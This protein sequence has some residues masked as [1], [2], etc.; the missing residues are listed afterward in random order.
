MIRQKVE[1]TP[2]VLWVTFFFIAYSALKILLPDAESAY[3]LMS[4]LMLIVGGLAGI[5]A[6]LSFG[7]KKN[8]TARI[9]LCFTIALF[10]ISI[11]MLSSTLESAFNL[12]GT[13]VLSL[14]VF[15]SFVAAQLI[16]TIALMTSVKSIADRVNIR[17]AIYLLLAAIF[18]FGVA[19]FNARVGAQIGLVHNQVD[20]FFWSGL[21]PSLIFLQLG[22]A[23]VLIDLLGRWYVTPAIRAVALGFVCFDFLYPPATVYILVTSLSFLGGQVGNLL[24]GVSLQAVAATYVVSLALTQMKPKETGP[25]LVR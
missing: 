22:T 21:M 13:A 3:S 19:W 4:S 17:G 18:S 23:L 2:Y 5:K 10:L 20:A 24:T 15:V 25:F 9:A 11:T 8:F 12:S 16:S 1:V 7:G 14:V 6:F